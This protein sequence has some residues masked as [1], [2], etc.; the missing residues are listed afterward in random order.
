MQ[1]GG[2][3]VYAVLLSSAATA[4]PCSASIPGTWVGG[5]GDYTLTWNG[6]SQQEFLGVRIGGSPSWTTMRGVFSPSYGNLDGFFF[7]DTKQVHHGV[8]N[9][10]D[11]CGSFSWNDGSSWVNA[12]IPPV[13][14]VHI[15][16]H[17]HD[18]VGWDETYSE[19]G[20]GGSVDGG[21]ALTRFLINSAILHGPRPDWSGPQRFSNP[22]RGGERAPPRPQAALLLRR[23]GTSERGDEHACDGG[24]DP[25]IRRANVT[26]PPS[27]IRLTF[28]FGSRHRHQS[29]RL[30]FAASSRTSGSSFSTVAGACTMRLHPRTSTCWTTRTLVSVTL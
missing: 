20:E 19:R 29:Y 17:T 28:R 21:S 2:F 9:V 7:K 23:A 8:G 24:L 11:S 5:G 12:P 30:R 16:P 6:T 4:S 13:I 1:Y 22:P 25:P 3:L 14:N 26:T 10:S 18:D 15:A 27:L